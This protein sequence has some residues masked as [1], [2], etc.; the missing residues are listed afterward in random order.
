MLTKRQKQIFDF[1]AL[2]NEKHEISPSLEEIR[3]HFKLRSVSNIHQHIE[4]I[5]SKGYLQKQKISKEG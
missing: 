3:K 4:A 1:V 2:Y 5:M